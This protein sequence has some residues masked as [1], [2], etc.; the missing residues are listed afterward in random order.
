MG[1]AEESYYDFMSFDEIIELQE[2]GA[3]ACARGAAE[4][5]NPF[6]KVRPLPGIAGILYEQWREKRDAWHFGWAIENAFRTPCRDV[7]TFH[8]G[9]V[10]G[11]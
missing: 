2:R 4:W 1:Y 11:Y 9:K 3:E 7:A 6:L 10:C 8:R 5:D